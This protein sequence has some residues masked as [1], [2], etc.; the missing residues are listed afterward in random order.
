MRRSRAVVWLVLVLFGGAALVSLPVE[1]RQDDATV[2]VVAAGLVNPRGFAFGPDGSLFTASGGSRERPAGVDRVVDGCPSR[3]VDDLPRAGVAFGA[4]AGVADLAFLG[5]QLFAL[6]AGGDTDRSDFPNGIYR[7]GSEGSMEL[8][9]DLSAFI[10]ENPVEAK[11]G[12]FDGDGQ[13]YAM[14]ATSADDG[15]FVT[16]GNSNQLLRVSLDG[17]VVRIAD[18]SAG[19]PIPTGVALRPGGGVYVSFLTRAPYPEGGSRVVLIASDGTSQEVWSGLSLVTALAV[20]GA[21]ELYALEMATGYGDDPSAIAPGSGRVV[22]RT[23]PTTGT[24][25]VEG[26]ALPV[27]MEFGPDGGLFVAGPA[28]GA[29]AGEGRIVR[30]DLAGSLPVRMVGELSG[31]ATCV[32]G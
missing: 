12:D 25:V 32:G 11:P 1:A 6:V 10:Q 9:G 18:L 2:R 13:P 28:F 4:V 3:F 20:D 15:F 22:R 14:V 21:G 17:T 30:I 5:D 31:T 7:V 16:E 27:A 23:G 26:L 24:A 19:H 8:M 29:D